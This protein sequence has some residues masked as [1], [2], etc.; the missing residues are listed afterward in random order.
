[1]TLRRW[2][3][4]GFHD[5]VWLVARS[6]W[7]ERV[8]VSPDVAAIEPEAAASRLDE[9]FPH[10]WGNAREGATLAEIAAALG[11]ELLWQSGPSV[12]ARRKSLIRQALRDGRLVALRVRLPA[13]A[14]SVVEQEEDARPAESAAQE[15]KTWIE[16][17][18][19]DD[20]DP[21]QPVPFK[22]YRVE[23]PDGAAR[24]GK[25]DANGRAMILGID[26]GTCEVSF[27]GIDA[28]EWRSA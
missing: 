17:V 27:P 10:A 18:L 20:S 24:E 15:D 23:L 8:D 6:G 3:V 28:G 11:E 7:G 5:G 9:W 16:I 14:G 4:E 13:P 1:M 26:P 21:P 19:V 25:L 2:W 12:A 22:R